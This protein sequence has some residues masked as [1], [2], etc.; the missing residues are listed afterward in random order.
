MRILNTKWI[1]QKK[2]V[3]LLFVLYKLRNTQICL[4]SKAFL[5]PVLGKHIPPTE[6]HNKPEENA[7]SSIFED[8]ENTSRQN[9][10]EG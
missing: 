3:V 4:L 5:V 1:I 9:G 6:C 10:V 7:C 8:S 2:L